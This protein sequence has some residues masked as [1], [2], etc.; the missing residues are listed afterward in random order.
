[1]SFRKLHS[2]ITLQNSHCSSKLASQVQLVRLFTKLMLE[3]NV[4]AAVW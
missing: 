2:V 3:G 1:M 4:R